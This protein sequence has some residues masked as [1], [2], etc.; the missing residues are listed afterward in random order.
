M[1]CH[2]KVTQMTKLKIQDPVMIHKMPH[3]NR[4]SIFS[5]HWNLDRI[6]FAEYVFHQSK[7]QNV[8]VQE[9]FNAFTMSEE[10]P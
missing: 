6:P 5:K 3:H 4:T 10:F 1:H 7:W 2:Y 8:C 9:S